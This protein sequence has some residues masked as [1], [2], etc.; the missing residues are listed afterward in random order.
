MWCIFNNNG[1][2][3]EYLDSSRR[4]LENVLASVPLGYY[5]EPITVENY[6]N[7]C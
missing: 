7:E 2:P 1:V 3:T 5:I 6:C 4:N